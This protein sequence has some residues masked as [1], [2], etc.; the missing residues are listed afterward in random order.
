MIMTKKNVRKPSAPHN[1][2]TWQ[3][4]ILVALR[5]F[6]GWHFLYEGLVKLLNP[7]W[8]AAGYLV[9]SR[10]IFSGLFKAIVASP[11]LLSIVDF[12]NIWGLILIGLGLMLGAFTRITTLAGMVLLAL[13][14]LSNPPFYGYSYSMPSE[15]SYII[16][17]KNFIEFLAL[18]VLYLFPTGCIIGLDRFSSLKKDKFMNRKPEGNP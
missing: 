10:W 4:T 14:Y 18:W 5:V 11:S 12:L 3:T 17:N 1:Y 8:S 7:Y 15:G 6:I 16:V 9:E 13:Y 2:T